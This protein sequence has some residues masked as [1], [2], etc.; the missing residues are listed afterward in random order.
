MTLD[1]RIEIFKNAFPPPP[2]GNTWMIMTQL[3]Y[4]LIADRMGLQTRIGVLTVAAAAAVILVEE[5]KAELELRR[6]A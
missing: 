2:E 6:E 4:D 1:E 3:V 5:L